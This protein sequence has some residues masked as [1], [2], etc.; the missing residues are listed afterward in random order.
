MTPAMPRNH[1]RIRIHI[2][3]IIDQIIAQNEYEREVLEL[4]KKQSFCHTKIFEPLF[5]IKTGLRQDMIHAF[6][7]VGWYDFA[8]IT[9]IG[10]QLLTMEFLMSLGIE[11]MAKTT[12]IYFCFFD[13]QY[14]LMTRELTVAL[15][16]SKKC[17]Q[18]PNARVKKLSI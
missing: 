10:S 7:Y 4:L 6:S 9:E 16:F 14:E 15:G 3:T 17:L 5:I 8:D 2:L 13:E 1:V 12:K 18:D 11:E